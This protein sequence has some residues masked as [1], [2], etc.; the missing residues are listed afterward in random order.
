M[1]ITEVTPDSFHEW[2]SLALTLWPDYTI[3]EMREA[4]TII[5]QSTR[6]AGFLIRND[7][8]TAIGF[9]NLS[10]RYDYVPG[11]TQSPVAFVEGIYVADAYRKQGVG[12][13]LLQ[14]A[15]AWARQRD[16]VELASDALLDNP[17]SHR[18]HA[19]LGFRE[20]ERLVAF[21]RPLP[22]QAPE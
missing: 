19:A 15:E 22:P 11:A 13:R 1:Q 17:D 6:Q 8:Q 7:S 21:I 3:E 4:L 14:H 10:L 2:L 18:F 16:C 12:R 20:V 5:S 9:I